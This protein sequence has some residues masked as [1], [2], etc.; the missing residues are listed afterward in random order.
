MRIGGII[1]EYNPFHNGHAYQ[2]NKLKQHCDAV[3]IIMSGSFVQRGDAAITDKFTRALAAVKNGANLVAELPT[4]YVL[5][6]AHQFAYGGVS[7]LKSL[8][9]DVLCF[10][11]ETDD[12]SMLI[13]TANKIDNETQEQSALMKKYLSAGYSY[14]HAFSKV[15]SISDS[16]L[17][18]MP[19]N[20]LAIEYIR[21]LSALCGNMEI[22]PIKRTG[23]MHDSN[24]VS[25][26]IASASYIRKLILSNKD[27]SKY[28]PENYTISDIRR[29]DKLDNA[30]ISAIRINGRDMFESI[31]DVSEGIENKIVYEAFRCCSINDLANAVKSKRYT[32]AR[33]NRILLNAFLRADKSLSHTA[34]DYIRVLAA[35]KMGCS[36]LKSISSDIDIITK[37]ADYKG[38]SRL[39]SLDITAGD[40]ASL[41]GNKTNGRTDYTISPFII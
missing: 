2:I 8:G 29:L 19:N 37:T 21:A 33:I 30:I 25:G 32:R 20:I 36:I 13:Y 16:T 10:G 14:P 24:A 22:L 34:P 11:T 40:V 15:F 26:N 27:I 41:C 28:V 12:T 17:L 39:F 4:A 31:G 23:V 38:G 5:S 3:V 35:D 18:S 1:A 9:S 7:L 6:S